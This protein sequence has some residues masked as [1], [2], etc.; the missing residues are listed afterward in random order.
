MEDRELLGWYIDEHSQ[1]AFSELVRR[2]INMVYATAL[3]HVG[4]DTYLADDVAQKV[5]SDLARKAPSL[6]TRLML[7]GWLY[8]GTRFAAAQAVR[9]ERRRRAHEQEAHAMNELDEVNQTSWDRLRPAIDDAMDG[10]SD[11]DREVILLRY[12]EHRPLAEVGARFSVSPDAA[13]MRVDRALAKLQKAFAKRGI[14]S[15]A[16]VLAAA[17]VSQSGVAAPA[18]LGASI[19]A[20]IFGPAG[21]ATL[22]T[23]GVWKGATVGIWK[24]A[25][26]LVIGGLGVGVAF[27]EAKHAQTSVQSSDASAA[28]APASRD[29]PRA[30]AIGAGSAG[31]SAA[32]APTIQTGAAQTIRQGIAQEA[33]RVRTVVRAGGTR[34]SLNDMVGE[35]DQ[36]VGLTPDQEAKA[37]AI[38]TQQIRAIRALP[39]LDERLEKGTGIRQNARAQIRELLTPE[40]QK[41]YDATPVRLG[42]GSL[43]DALSPTDRLDKAV[44]LT[45]EQTLQAA[46][47][48]QH[49]FDALN[50]LSAE[51]RPKEGLKIHR[52]ALM[53]V[54][55]LLTPEQQQK[56]DSNPNSLED[57]DVRAY[58]RSFINSSAGI[59]ARLGKV[60]RILPA[61]STLFLGDNFTPTYM[62]GTRLYK[63]DGASGSDTLAAGWTKASPSSA[64]QAEYMKGVYRYKVDGASGSDT[65]TVRWTK[66]S[67]SSA[68][69][70]D[71]I[72][73]SGGEIAP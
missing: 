62:R 1:E 64:V 6:R 32:S 58:L 73:G 51:D 19:V 24:I 50:A 44:T 29:E 67:P 41:I 48:F 31:A 47:I 68:V 69:Q 38:F 13:R 59:A 11:A 27:Y 63:V 15:T 26:G 65:L 33:P 2:H 12:F 72:E 40:Q 5:F 52:S 20:G 21:A 16:A 43:R 49:E 3:R 7:A 70:V 18:G 4:G 46:T 71:K 37:T 39:N 56:F 35:L 54:R 57:L 61:G 66:A 34:M 30:A 28:T 17:F 45:D 8:R 53:Q 42:G 55:A 36:L 10:L 22:A 14:D 60:A 9:T 23:A 25:A